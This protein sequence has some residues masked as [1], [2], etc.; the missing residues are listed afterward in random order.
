MRIVPGMGA[1]GDVKLNRFGI[2][3][4]KNEANEEGRVESEE[5]KT[6]MTADAEVGQYQPVTRR[7]AW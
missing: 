7:D 4:G 5:R 3:V 2:S 6:K 1:P